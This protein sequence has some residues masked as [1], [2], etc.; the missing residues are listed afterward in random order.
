MSEK[1]Q[2]ENINSSE[3][4]SQTASE[5][6][7]A[8]FLEL[9][10]SALNIEK[11][12]EQQTNILSAEE[13]PSLE[14]EVLVEEKKQ[15]KEKKPKEKKF[16]KFAKKSESKKS[17]PVAEENQNTVM[18]ESSASADE[19]EIVPEEKIVEPENSVQNEK[20]S[21]VENVA[22][23][24]EK[25]EE[26]KSQKKAKKEKVVK[27]KKQKPVKEKKI[28]TGP[29]YWER[30]YAPEEKSGKISTGL[31]KTVMARE[32]HSYFTSPIAYIVTAL[33]LVSSGFLFFS[34][35][36][37]GDRAE[38]RNF[39]YRLP[40]LF[41]F[42]IPALT[43]RI[44]AEEK[45]SGSLETLMTLP[46]T[47]FD[48]VLG[49][50]LATLISSLA[51]LVPTLS[52]VIACNMFGHPD[53][54]PIWGGY[55]GAIFLAAAFTAVGLFSSS[56]TKNQILAFFMALAICIFSTFV[57]SF[58]VLLPPFLATLFTF[59]SASSH[60]DSISRGILDSRDLIY[61]ISVTALFVALTVRRLNKSRR[62]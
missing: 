5:A 9:S 17:E 10:N 47:T 39:F 30:L 35:F 56:V 33:F 34:T 16:F 53:G 59:I 27:E 31:W 14:E 38:L 24:T 22:E 61:F 37:L 4:S 26:P 41:S 6:L 25:I 28:K 13:K 55:I 46:V 42:F 43:M 57:G 21:S 48:V 54:G 29:N 36:F 52:Y 45:K 58:I 62:D 32:L 19:N 3:S 51:M 1:N 15:K 12:I 60:F 44:F 11:E 49:K 23:V 7:R 18:E 40:V 8:A 2:N 20:D 50:Y